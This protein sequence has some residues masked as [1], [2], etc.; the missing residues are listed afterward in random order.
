MEI[1]RGT[2]F[3]FLFGLAFGTAMIKFGFY[4]IPMIW[5]IANLLLFIVLGAIFGTVQGNR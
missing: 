2:I 1:N 3:G 4:N 5:K